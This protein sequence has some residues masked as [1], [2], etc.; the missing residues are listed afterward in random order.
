MRLASLLVKRQLMAAAVEL[1]SATLAFTAFSRLSSSPLRLRRQARARTLSSI[2]AIQ[3]TTM[4]GR[5]VELQPPGDA[6]GSRQREGL[7]QE[8]RPVSV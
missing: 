3:P 4:L 7:V 2:S 6:A 8:R 1:R 5:V